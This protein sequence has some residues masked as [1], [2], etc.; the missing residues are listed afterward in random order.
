M[1]FFLGLFHVRFLDSDNIFE[2]YCKFYTKAIFLVSKVVLN[3]KISQI[4]KIIIF[5]RVSESLRGPSLRAT[6]H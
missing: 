4:L 1:R 6:A 3:S 5:F 2:K